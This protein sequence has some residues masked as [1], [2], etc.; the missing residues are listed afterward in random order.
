MRDGNR[1]QNSCNR[2]NWDALDHAS[3]ASQ[4]SLLQLLHVHQEAASL[5]HLNRIKQVLTQCCGF[6]TQMIIKVAG[7]EHSCQRQRKDHSD[8]DTTQQVYIITQ[9]DRATLYNL[10]CN[11]YLV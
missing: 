3:R 8:I 7:M 4:L 5:K 6:V 2:L 10:V 11:M 1:V 9:R